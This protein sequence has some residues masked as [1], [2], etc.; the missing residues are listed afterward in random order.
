MAAP[1]PHRVVRGVAVVLGVGAV[2]TALC[3]WY[4]SRY[5]ADETLSLV[6]A[7]IALAVTWV[8]IPLVT[9]VGW[10]IAAVPVPAAVVVLS[11]GIIFTPDGGAGGRAVIPVGIFSLLIL[12]V[13]VALA[14]R[15]AGRKARPA[16]PVYVP[17]IWSPGDGP[18]PG[19]AP[20]PSPSGAV[21]GPFDGADRPGPEDAPPPARFVPLDPFGAH[22]FVGPG[23]PL[24]ARPTTPA[25]VPA[26][27]PADP[28]T[29]RLMRDAF[30]AGLRDHDGDTAPVA[31]G[32]GLFFAGN[33]DR[34]SIGPRVAAHPG[35]AGIRDALFAVQ[36]TV[37]VDELVIETRPLRSG[38]F[39]GQD[40]PPAA[41][42]R[43]LTSRSLEDLLGL[44]A[45]VQCALPWTDGGTTFADGR[46]GPDGSRVVSVAW[47]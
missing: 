19:P 46:P 36:Q 14:V 23:R 40:W 12:L 41:R 31:V 25:P 1:Q 8:G 47:D 45:G 42:V 30:V 10:T 34:A 4:A 37:G 39:V 20:S 16:G 35:L 15:Q 22:F 27:A 2:F 21:G 11:S 28:A 5:P 33:G 29:N 13:V 26:G 3:G 17:P 24:P 44:L 38:S 9:R 43:V 6:C 32:V 7:G 18:G